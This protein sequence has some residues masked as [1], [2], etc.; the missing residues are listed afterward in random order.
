MIHS[1]NVLTWL[2]VLYDIGECFVALKSY[3]I[4]AFMAD[5]LEVVIN[6]VNYKNR[7][8]HRFPRHVG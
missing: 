1:G 5:G 7:L 8:P 6:Q 3:A 2:R 4:I